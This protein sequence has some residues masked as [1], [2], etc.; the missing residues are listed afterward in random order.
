VLAG[1]LLGGVIEQLEHRSS[2]KN[3]GKG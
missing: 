2:E 1:V 3:E